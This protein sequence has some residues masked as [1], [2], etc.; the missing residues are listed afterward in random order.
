MGCVII[1]FGDVGRTTFVPVLKTSLE[2]TQPEPHHFCS[3]QP[4]TS[5]FTREKAQRPTNTNVPQSASVIYV[6]T[7]TTASAPQRVLTGKPW[8]RMIYADNSDFA[9]LVTV[10]NGG[11]V[12]MEEVA[13]GEE[14]VEAGVSGLC[15]W[16]R[17]KA[18]SRGRGR[19][20]MGV[21][22]VQ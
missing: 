1:R 5:L 20:D 9:P 3:Q 19:E 11:A 2:L 8:L 7:D 15:I 16:V 12:E 17:V 22:A 14:F 10:K 6:S 18:G 21:S 13:R 4:R